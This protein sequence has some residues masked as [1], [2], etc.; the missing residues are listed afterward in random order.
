ME[1]RTLALISQFTDGELRRLAEFSLSLAEIDPMAK[2]TLYDVASMDP[3]F[4]FALMDQGDRAVAGIMPLLRKGQE[5]TGRDNRGRDSNVVR[6]APGA[7]L[8]P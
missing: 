4:A 5:R 3:G 2:Q 1:E 6:S 7:T 8:L